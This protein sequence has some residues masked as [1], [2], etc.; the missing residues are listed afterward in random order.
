M[1]I[2]LTGKKTYSLP[3]SSSKQTDDKEIG[4]KIS[5]PLDLEQDLIELIQAEHTERTKCKDLSKRITV[6]KLT[7]MYTSLSQAGFSQSQI[8]TCMNN[9]VMYGGDLIDALDWFCLN[10]PNE[11]LPSGFSTALE[12]EEEKIRPKFDAQLQQNVNLPAPSVKLTEIKAKET[13][14]KAPEKVVNMKDWIMQYAEVESDED[15]DDD[16]KDVTNK[17]ENDP[18][19]QYLEL[20]AKLLDAKAAASQAKSHGNKDKQKE[21][22]KVIRELIQRMDTLEKH[23]KFNPQVKINDIDSEKSDKVPT[24]VDE[25]SE[26]ILPDSFTEESAS[27]IAQGVSVTM[28]MESH[29]QEEED[30]ECSGF[31]LFEQMASVPEPEE[32]K[33]KRSDFDVRNFEYTRQQWTGK[34]PKQ[35]LIDWCRK[36]KCEAPK[37]EKVHVMGNLWRSKV[38]IDRRKDG[39]LEVCPEICCENFTEAQHLGSTL[40]LYN[41]CKGQSLHQLLP[42]PY[43]TV[44]M[45]WQDAEKAAAKKEKVEENK[46]RDQYITRLMKKLQISEKQSNS[47]GRCDDDGTLES[48]ED[49]EEEEVSDIGNKASQQKVV[50]PSHRPSHRCLDGRALS[51][52]Y[53]Q[54]QKSDCYTRLL[55]TRESLPVYQHKDGIMRAISDNRVVVIAGETGSGK[56][57]QIPQFVLETF[58]TCGNGDKCNIVC[59]EPRRISAVSLATRVSQE[60]GDSCLGRQDSLCGYQIRFESRRGPNT[61]LTY[62][63]TGVLLRQLQGD[64]LLPGVSHVIVDEVHER[65]VQSDFLMVILKRLLD[66]R[67]DLKV[68]LMSATL[69]SEKFSSYFHHCPVV[70]IPG[71]TFPV[72][73]F[74]VEDIIEKTGFVL[75]HDSP[76][77]FRPEQLIKEE[78][79]SISVTGRGGEQTKTDVYWTTQNISRIDQTSLSPDDYSLQTRNTV[80]R[81]NPDY[82]NMDIIVDLLVYIDKDSEFSDMEGSVLIFLPGL[83]DIQELHELLTTDRR[84]SN[85]ARYQIL[86]LHSVLSS[87]DQSAAFVTPL[88]GVRKV[89]IATNIAETGI[90]IPD[91]V[92]VIDAGKVKENRYMES[93]QMSALREVFISKASAKQRQGRAGRVR[94]GVCLRLYTKEKYDSLHAFTTPEIQRVPL[95]ELCLHI[96]KCN[97]GDPEVFLSA[98]LDPPRSQVISRAMALLYEVGACSGGATLTP[99]G[100]HLATL[101]VNVRIGKMLLFGA[102]FGYLEPVAVIAAAMTTKSPFVA[103][104]Q[105]LDLAQSMK[106]S[107]AAACSDHL[108]VY[109]AYVGWKLAQK[110]AKSHEHQF[111]AKHFLKR[112]TLLEIENLKWDLIKLVESIGFSDDKSSGKKD[113]PENLYIRNSE[114]TEIPDLEQNMVAMVKAVVAAGLYPNVAKVT[115]D[116]PV[117]AK[118]NPSK[119]V[120]VGETAQGPAN[121][122]P[123]SVNRNLATNGWLAYQEKVTTSKVY[124]RECTL[125]SPFSLMMFG[126]DIHVE[127][128]SQCVVIDQ[129]IK[130][131][132][133]AR[134][135]VLFKELRKLLSSLLQEKLQKPS[136]SLKDDKI[137]NVIHKL[138]QIEGRKSI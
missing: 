135:G 72:Q 15:D 69:D 93:S 79:S 63:T 9:T 131:K 19:E 26:S 81:L 51:D 122:H 109:R 62:C 70:N 56:S 52:M 87:S 99:L 91:V 137:I 8:E 57:T 36:H 130:F 61:R 50:R 23:P 60:L 133:N 10:L 35:F 54:H 29:D 78:H 71:R 27:D 64:P 7:D 96:M 66:Q 129:R 76:Y 48:W 58:L 67:S 124:I 83:A 118:A 116:A 86:A 92:F 108:T 43:R 47:D 121:V 49:F 22:S 136:L 45:E 31:A 112:N 14:K 125:V 53:K 110:G 32:K 114:A 24:P 28:E 16:L 18:N 37:Y 46:P 4:P 75:D 73:V 30:D 98:A 104:L 115:Y 41:L 97:L 126:G 33:P 82:I 101:P 127:H 74:H 34:S 6:K 13:E 128:L 117:D 132:T 119:N 111:C 68:I 1:C 138:L 3:V 120:C 88:P 90:T 100:H 103:P 107:M 21:L 102:I 42:P 80:T 39:M 44:W 123:S 84:F 95:E 17:E 40:A 38:K 94:E 85:P 25:I 134:T 65:S 113:T 11:K 77:A 12:K 59:T 2:L 105:K 89:V 55:K 5:V 106:M 20:T